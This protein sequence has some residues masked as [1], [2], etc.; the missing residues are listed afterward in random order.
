MGSYTSPTPST[1]STLSPPVTSSPGNYNQGCATPQHKDTFQSQ[2]VNQQSPHSNR[3]PSSKL[4]LAPPYQAMEPHR[5][6]LVGG[7]GGSQATSTPGRG[8]RDQHTHAQM[9]P[10]NPAASSSVPY[11]H[12]QPHLGLGHHGPPPPPSASSTAV[13]QQSGPHEVW[14]H[15][16]RPSHSLVSN[17]CCVFS[18]VLTKQTGSIG[19]MY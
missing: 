3:S 8:D 19:V 15:Q 18:Y 2:A 1:P 6:P 14:R 5:S 4:G 12:F 10:A 13:P 16:N 7:A 11:R 17:M 9:S